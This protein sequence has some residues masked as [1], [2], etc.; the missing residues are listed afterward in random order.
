MVEDEHEEAQNRLQQMNEKIIELGKCSDENERFP[1]V[2]NKAIRKLQTYSMLFRFSVF[3]VDS[4]KILY[5]FL[6]K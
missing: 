2:M 4:T 5:F 3:L 1:I 6:F